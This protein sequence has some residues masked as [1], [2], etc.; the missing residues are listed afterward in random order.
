MKKEELIC[1]I[2][3]RDTLLADAV[4]QMVDYVTDKYPAAYPNKEQT[5][6]VNRY[7]QSV[8]A[9]GD[10]TMSKENSEHRRIA[11]QRITLNAIRLLDW[12]QQNRMQDVLDHIAYDRDYYLP[13]RGWKMRR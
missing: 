13:E 7:L 6:A 3:E 12:E 5:A 9:D 8:R 2:R 10:G 11:S 1:I 4:S